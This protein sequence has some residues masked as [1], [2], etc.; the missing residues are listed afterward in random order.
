MKLTKRSVQAAAAPLKGQKIIT[1]DEFRGFALRIM[2]T[3]SRSFLL[4]YWV[5]G[6]ERRKTIGPWPEWSV[7]AAREEAAKMRRLLDVGVDP[8]QEDDNRRDSMTFTALV[9][10]YTKVETSKQKRGGEYARILEREAVPVWGAWKVQDIRR[11]DVIGLIERKAEDAPV[12]ANRLYELLRRMFNFAIR[13]DVLEANPCAQVRKPGAERSK[14]RVLSRN[15]IKVFWTTLDGKAFRERTAAALRM[16]LLTAARPGEVCAMK[17]SDVDMENGV[18]TISAEGSKN[19]LAH[20]VPLNSLAI[21]TLKGIK[22]RRRQYVFWTHGELGRRTPNALALAIRKAR[23][24]KTD[25]LKIDAFTPHDLRRTAASMMASIGVE[26]FT[27]ARVLNHAETGITRVYDRYGYD[28]EKRT[29]LDRWD[30][31]LR[32]ILVGRTVN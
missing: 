31:E 4:R 1:D 28:Q 21:E 25:P 15:E 18:W 26:R 27:V 5:D 12:A 32:R 29:A 9:E 30:A 6:R 23:Q 14:D 8:Q 22:G 16:I 20:R 24:R 3:G 7:A 19:G 17:W 10:E 13:R 11:R 2:P